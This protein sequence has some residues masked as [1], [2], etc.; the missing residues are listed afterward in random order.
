VY[1]NDTNS[2]YMDPS[3]MT[4]PLAKPLGALAVS[5]FGAVVSVVFSAGVAQALAQIGGDLAPG[6]RQAS[7][8]LTLYDLGQVAGLPLVWILGRGLGRGRAM[9][10]AGLGYALASA[11]VALAP[12]LAAALP[13]RVVQGLF[14]GMMPV[15]VML[16]VMSSLR[17]GQGQ[18]EGLAAYA[19]TATIGAGVSTLVAVGLL[20]L[21]GWRMLFWA[22]AMLGLL[23]ALIASRTLVGETGQRQALHQADWPGYALLTASLGAFVVAVSEGGRHGW[24]ETWWVTALLL[25]AAALLGLSLWSLSRSPAPLLRLSIF[26]RPTFRWSILIALVFRG[27]ALL[28]VWVAPQ[29]LVRLQGYSMAEV[30][31]SLL[32]MGP[33]T[34]AALPVAYGLTRYLDPRLPLSLGLALFAA[35]AWVGAGLSP[36]GAAGQLTLIASLTAVG[37]T[38][39]MVPVLRFAV[40]GIEAI[41]GLTCGVLFNLAR[42]LG[43]VLATAGLTQLV[44]GREQLLWSRLG[45]SVA[46]TDLVQRLTALALADAAWLLAGLALLALVITWALP[47]LKAREAG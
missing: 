36:D 11:G 9:A 40:H 29:Y 14:G 41:D 34:L 45:D 24:L 43:Q 44:A 23:Y 13:L 39:V 8:I 31:D 47:S 25:V 15:F 3:P 22:P 30:G 12:D 2:V 7:W 19:L 42:L 35:A 32:V 26:A 10:L 33:A 4:P 17:P 18:A 20:E 28:A 27:P 16:M 38:L 37:Q 21:G 5:L 46:A 1:I 6:S